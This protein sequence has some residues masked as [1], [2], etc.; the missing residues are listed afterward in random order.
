MKDP[1][2]KRIL[3]VSAL[4]AVLGHAAWAQSPVLPAVPIEIT[5]GWARATA[6]TAK[7]GAAYLTIVNKGASDDRLIAVAG[8]VAAKAELHVTSMDNGVMKMRP[9]AA[10]DIKAGATAELKPGGMHIMLIGLAAPLKEGQSFPLALTFE[11]AGTVAITISVEKAGAMGD[12]AMP[13]MKTPGM[14]M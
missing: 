12:H 10:V 11:K 3:S 6:A 13:D 7:T 8:P 1:A 2:M 9:I 14:K 4:C 5:H